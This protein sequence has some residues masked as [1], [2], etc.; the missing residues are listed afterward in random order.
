MFGPLP[1]GRH[2]IL[3]KRTFGDPID[4]TTDV[5]YHLTVGG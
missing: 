3:F 1:D 5:T 2:T 4:F